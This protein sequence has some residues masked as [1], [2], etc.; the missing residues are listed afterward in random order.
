[1]CSKPAFRLGPRLAD[2]GGRLWQLALRVH[3]S[4]VFAVFTGTVIASAVVI[5]LTAAGAFTRPAAAAPVGSTDRLKTGPEGIGMSCNRLRLKAAVLSALL[6][7]LALVAFTQSA[8]ASAAAAHIALKPTVGRPITKVSVSGTGFAHRESVVVDFR[9]TKVATATTSLTGTFAASF[10][11]PRAAQPGTAAVKAIGQ[12]SKATATANFVVRTD[13][14]MLRFDIAGTG[15]NPYE[16]LLS[17]TNVAHL[18]QAWAE[19]SSQSAFEPASPPAAYNGI[20]YTGSGYAGIDLYAYNPATGAM[21]WKG[22]GITGGTSGSAHTPAVAGGVSYSA[23]SDGHLY[24]YSTTVSSARCSGVPPVTCKPLWSGAITGAGSNDQSSPVVSGGVVY[25]AAGYNL[26]AFKAGGCGAAVC[27]PLWVSA[28]STLDGSSTP[29]VSGGVIY[30]G[31]VSGLYAY[32]TTVSS[33][34]CSGTAPVTCKPKWIGNAANVGLYDSSPAVANG[35]VY[36]TANPGYGKLFAFG[37][38]CTSSTCN[39]LWSYTSTVPAGFSSPAVAGGK[40]Y[41][42]STVASLYVFDTSGARVWTAP[43][44]GAGTGSA[45]AP[46]VANGV[47]YTGFKGRAEAYSAAGSTGCSGTPEVCA[48]LWTLVGSNGAIWDT[49]IAV[50]GVVYA[51]AFNGTTFSSYKLP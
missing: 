24:A 31:G 1:M 20:L 33:A 45:A 14:P 3:H 36:L 19:P 4:S 21:L 11:V 40:I 6:A 16:N 25:V 48:P 43:A 7:V 39:A 12:T 38:G 17:S 18:A 26:Y 2:V 27:R 42:D 5:G 47:V 10:T 22:A 44:P 8:P 37:T 15:N 9:T 41:V 35:V 29:A 13:W 23:S 51:R 49:P 50:N 32:S 34:R 28:G 46:T 30:I